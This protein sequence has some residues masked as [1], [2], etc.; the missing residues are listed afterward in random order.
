MFY[1]DE[2]DSE[3]KAGIYFLLGAAYQGNG[4]TDKACEAYTNAAV[5][6]YEANANYQEEHVL[7]CGQ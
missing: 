3:K 7:K 5:G 2:N 4:E 6:K 1:N